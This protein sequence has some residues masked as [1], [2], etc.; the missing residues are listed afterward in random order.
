MSTK[1]GKRDD[2]Q[3]YRVVQIRGGSNPMWKVVDKNGKLFRTF[4]NG[5]TR[6]DGHLRA[7]NCMR[8]QNYSMPGGK[9]AFEKA[10]AKQREQKLYE[11]KRARERG[12]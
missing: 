12:Y 4:S 8:G 1:P 6:A 10:E 7:C 2:K 11:E 5:V 9:E 3:P